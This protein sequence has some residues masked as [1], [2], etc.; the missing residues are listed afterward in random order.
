M[1]IDVPSRPASEETSAEE[2]R[3]QSH[4]YLRIPSAARIASHILVWISVLLPVVTMIAKGWIPIGD[5]AAIASRS[6][7]TFSSHPPLV[8]LV[9]TAG[10]GIG[11][12]LFDPGPLQFWLLSIP[13]RL[14]SIHGA[15][16]G[17]QS[18]LEFV[19]SL[20]VEIAW[21]LRLPIAGLCIALS[22]VLM[23]WL[24]PA[25]FENVA[26]NAYFPVAFL[27]LGV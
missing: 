15:L 5:N 16:W 6:F 26:W 20:S 9:T 8:G 4:P 21:S 17:G 27:V 7:Q 2:A 24:T 18:L 1:I 11:H 14:D 22:A 3:G 25:A 12:V 10:T 13:V 23:L 19:W